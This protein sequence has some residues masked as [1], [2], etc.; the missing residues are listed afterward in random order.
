MVSK[1]DELL[2]AVHVTDPFSNV[3]RPEAV[4]SQKTVTPRTFKQ[5][6]QQGLNKLYGM[7]RTRGYRRVCTEY[8]FPSRNRPLVLR[9]GP[10]A[11]APSPSISTSKLVSSLLDYTVQLLTGL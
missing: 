2:E 5:R 6:K 8:V 7:L 9:S 3:D 4:T 11:K 1:L 10:S